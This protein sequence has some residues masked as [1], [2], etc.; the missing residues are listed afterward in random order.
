M[1]LTFV[2]HQQLEKNGVTGDKAGEDEHEP[3]QR[4][5]VAMPH[6]YRKPGGKRSKFEPY[7]ER[8]AVLAVIVTI[9]HL[10]YTTTLSATVY[11]IPAN[12]Y[13]PYRL[14]TKFPLNMT[15]FCLIID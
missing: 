6:Q 4:R 3:Q 8:I 13:L 1:L 12:I 5:E 15:S 9:R 14:Y 2:G 7:P 11:L 10:V